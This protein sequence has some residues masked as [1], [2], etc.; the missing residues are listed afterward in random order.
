[1]TLVLGVGERPDLAERGLRHV[2][3]DE[4]V[5]HRRAR[6]GM[7]GVLVAGEEGSVEGGLRGGDLVG[8]RRGGERDGPAGERS[9]VRREI[10]LVGKDS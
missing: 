7:S 1:M 4:E 10:K 5:K 3:R 8:A 6:D 9:T 2:R